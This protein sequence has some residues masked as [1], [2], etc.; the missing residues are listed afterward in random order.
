MNRGLKKS[1]LHKN[2]FFLYFN[3]WI[4]PGSCSASS[5]TCRRAMNP[6]P[7]FQTF[8]RVSMLALHVSD[9]FTDPSTWASSSHSS[10]FP[11]HKYFMVDWGV[12]RFAVSP[13]YSPSFQLQFLDWLWDIYFQDWLIFTW[14]HSAT[15]LT[16]TMPISCQWRLFLLPL[17]YKYIL[18]F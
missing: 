8:S 9:L 13:R 11:P 2:R 15:R 5:D 17:F 18:I 14:I 4:R 6:P 3:A 7:C 16:K 1:S 12:P 10:S